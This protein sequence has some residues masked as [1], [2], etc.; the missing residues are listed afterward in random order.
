MPTYDYRCQECSE[1]FSKF[2]SISEKDQVKCQKCGGQCQQLFTGFLYNKKTGG[3][4][5]NGSSSS[6]TKSSCSGCKGC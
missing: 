4:I 5:S 6:C 2:V 1:K 3:G